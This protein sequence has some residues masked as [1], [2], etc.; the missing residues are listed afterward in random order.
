MTRRASWGR[1]INSATAATDATRDRPTLPQ[2]TLP[3]A[4]FPIRRP[5]KPFNRKPSNGQIGISQR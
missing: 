4:L 5:K 1:A 3:T 2:A